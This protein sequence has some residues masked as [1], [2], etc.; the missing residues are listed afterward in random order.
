MLI[1][2]VG[3]VALAAAGWF[4][5]ARWRAP[6]PTTFTT[7]PAGRGDVVTAVTASG[8]LSPV[9]QVDVGSQVSGRLAEVLVDYNDAVKAGQVI[10]RLDPEVFESAVS[11]AKARLG[12][13]K[14]DL[15]RARAVA[16]NARLQHTRIAGMVEAGLVAAADVDAALAETRSADSQVIAARA[17]VTEA[18]AAL[19]QARTNLAYT[20]ITSPIDGIVISRSVDPGQTVAASLS[21]PILFV[22]AGDLRDMEVHTSVAESDVGQ[23]ATGVKVEFS[24]DAFPERTFAGTVKQV[25]YEAQTVSNVVSYDA[26][27]SVRNEELLLRPGMT[28]NATFVIAERADVL[29]VP[30]KA[31]RYQPPRQARPARDGDD[32]RLPAATNPRRG[33]RRGDAVWVLRDGAPVRVRVETGLTD[34]T[35]TEVTG[36]EL[37]EGDL[38]IT[39]DSTARAAPATQG[40]GNRGSRGGAPRGPF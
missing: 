2:A 13:A 1:A 4:A 10:A 23:L 8:T 19:E 31:L 20:T 9:I 15:E 33:G 17:K 27:I 38:V 11:Q 25:R 14:A 34:G 30:S 3:L 22:I 24:V 29:T 16:K 26:V 21:A 39:A 28:A 40:N 6:A 12:S 32:T 7:S 36:G 18:E 37:A 35:V 5:Y